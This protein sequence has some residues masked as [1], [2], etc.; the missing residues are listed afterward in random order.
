MRFDE[1]REAH[2]VRAFR[3][4][5]CVYVWGCVGGSYLVR[6]LEEAVAEEKAERGFDDFSSDP[7]V[8]Y[9]AHRLLPPL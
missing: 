6:M 9:Y 4:V 5:L 7:S 1:L 8:T 2:K 3:L